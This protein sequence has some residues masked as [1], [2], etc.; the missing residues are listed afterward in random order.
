VLKECPSFLGESAVPLPDEDT[1]TFPMGMHSGRKSTY[2]NKTFLISNALK[3][4]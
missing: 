2:L 4:K 1:P 3:R